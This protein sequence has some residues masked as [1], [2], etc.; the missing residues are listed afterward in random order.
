MDTN[1][2]ADE[3]LLNDFFYIASLTTTENQLVARVFL[4]ADHSIYEGHFPDRPIT[5]GVCLVEI[6]KE[7]IMIASHKKLQLYQ[8]NHIKFVQMVDPK[9]TPWIDISIQYGLQGRQ[10]GASATVRKDEVI[11]CKFMGTFTIEAGQM[12]LN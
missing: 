9:K 12:G 6:I 8:C 5:P 7:I 4:N 2:Q 3:L 1:F 11:F 10:I